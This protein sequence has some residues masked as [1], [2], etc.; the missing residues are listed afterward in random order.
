MIKSEYLQNIE[1]FAKE[2][3]THYTKES[4]EDFFGINIVSNDNVTY[5]ILKDSEVLFEKQESW[6]VR[7][8]LQEIIKQIPIK[9][10][11]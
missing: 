2:Q 6:Q 10:L 7:Q 8:M 3:T 9:D 11:F 5:D 4:I 1:N